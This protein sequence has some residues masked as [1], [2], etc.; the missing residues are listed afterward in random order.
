MVFAYL[1]TIAHQKLTQR[2]V[3][4]DF[5]SIKKTS[6]CQLPPESEER[7]WPTLN[8]CRGR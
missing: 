7:L 2:C 6:L 1:F 4:F 3:K 5:N 8:M